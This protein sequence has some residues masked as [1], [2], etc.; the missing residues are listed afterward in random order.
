MV[1]P[2]VAPMKGKKKDQKTQPR[3]GMKS[4]VMLVAKSSIVKSFTR[5]EVTSN[6]KQVLKLDIVRRQTSFEVM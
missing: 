6:G 5:Y 4:V 2:P 3:L 1:W